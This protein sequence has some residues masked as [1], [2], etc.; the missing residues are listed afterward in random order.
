MRSSSRSVS[1]PPADD[2]NSPLLVTHA[3]FGAVGR[4]LAELDRAT[5]FVHEGGYVL[6]T[7]AGLTLVVLDGFE[8]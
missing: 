6:E 1:T 5:V 8:S 3:G 7:L 2:P 4:L